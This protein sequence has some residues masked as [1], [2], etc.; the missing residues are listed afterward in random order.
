MENKSH[1]SD[2]LVKACSKGIGDIQAKLIAASIATELMKSLSLNRPD[3]VPDGN[4]GVRVGECFAA[5]QARVYESL[6]G[7]KPKL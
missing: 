5:V 4:L 3:Q 6:A 2:E 1:I 7:K